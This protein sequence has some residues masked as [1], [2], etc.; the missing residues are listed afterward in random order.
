MRTSELYGDLYLG[1]LDDASP[2]PGWN[3]AHVINHLVGT[4]SL[5]TSV[6]HDDGYAEEMAEFASDRPYIGDDPREM[7]REVAEENLKSWRVP[8]ALD[9]ICRYP[10]GGF[11]DIEVPGQSAALINLEEVVVHAWDVATATGSY[12][13]FDPE[14]VSAVYE[15]CTSTLTLDRYRSKRFFGRK[16]AVPE[17]AP[18]LDRLVGHLGRHP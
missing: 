14:L 17:S 8:D 9:A 5:F 12:P 4:I 15:F 13:D 16:V 6:N 10:R 11:P 2:C 1:R 3:V 7:F 18:L